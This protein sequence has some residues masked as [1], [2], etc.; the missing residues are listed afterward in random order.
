[1]GEP[2][3]CLIQSNVLSKWFNISLN[4]VSLHAQAEW[5]RYSLGIKCSSMWGKLTPSE[6]QG[7]NG[8]LFLL[9]R[10]NESNCQLIISQGMPNSRLRFLKMSWGES[11]PSFQL[12]ILMGLW[13]FPPPFCSLP[14]SGPVFRWV[15]RQKDVNISW[16]DKLPSAI[17]RLSA[18]K[19]FP[20]AVLAEPW[21]YFKVQSVPTLKSELWFCLSRNPMAWGQS[22]WSHTPSQGLVEA[23]LCDPGWSRGIRGEVCWEWPLVRIT[24]KVVSRKKWP[25]FYHRMSGPLTARAILSTREQTGSGGG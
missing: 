11:V 15:Y 21:F 16:T 12:V 22:W 20:L 19:S 3:E 2:G 24:D 6:H 13:V 8:K 18:Q 7:V 10:K 14:C 17:S 1:M 23:W 5:V 4:W 25:L 9:W